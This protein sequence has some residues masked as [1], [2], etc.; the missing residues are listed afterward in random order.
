MANL[1]IF[2]DSADAREVFSLRKTNPSE[3]FGLAKNLLEKKPDDIWVKRAFAWTLY[4]QIKLCLKNKNHAEAAEYFAI[5]QNLNIPKEKDNLRLFEKFHSLKIKV[6]SEP[7]EIT[8][9][10]SMETEKQRIESLLS[11]IPKD[12]TKESAEQIGRSFYRYLKAA[13]EIKKYDIVFINKILKEYNGL[14]LEKP[15]E[16]HSLIFYQITHLFKNDVKGLDLNVIMT[17]WNPPYDLT[18]VDFK[19]VMLDGKRV[20]PNAEKFIYAYIKLLL[21]LGNKT[22]IKSYLS[23][24]EEMILRFPKYSWLPYQKCKLLLASSS[25]KEEIL[26]TIIPFVRKKSSEFWTWS[27]LGEALH[28]V[29]DKA[30]SCY[31]KALTNKGSDTFLVKVRH[32]LVKLLIMKKMYKEAKYEISKILE[33]KNIEK[34]KIPSDINGWLKE[35]WYNET[36]LPVNNSAFYNHNLKLAEDIIFGE[37]V[38]T[39]IGV[40][41]NVDKVSGKAYYSISKIITG[42]FKPKKQQLIKTGD[43][44]EFKLDEKNIGGHINFDVLSAEKSSKL[45]SKDIY[46]EFEGVLKISKGGEIGFIDS[47]HLSKSMIESHKLKNNNLVKGIAIYSTDKKRNDFGWKA[48]KVWKV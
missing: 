27:T 1:N 38:K 3:A 20:M 8:G 48:I 11:L 44:Y 26:K 17:C 31:C 13:N 2:P 36:P 28:S 24:I 43:F 37:S 32:N 45:P 12:I 42:E 22:Y 6:D 7:D 25:D 23:Q 10:E 33:I 40:I 39:Y 47:V 34:Q 4:D 30:I 5:Y 18:S 41:T 21:Q 15:S 29:P 16:L 19:E 9:N 46:R 14:L 35:K